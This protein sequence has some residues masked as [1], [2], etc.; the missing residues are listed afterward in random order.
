MK[1]WWIQACQAWD[2]WVTDDNFALEIAK[3][4]L[5]APMTLMCIVTTSTWMTDEYIIKR[6][7]TPGLETRYTSKY[8]YVQGEA[9]N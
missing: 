5:T 6:Y 3:A 9:T 1:T 2:E 7:G 4:A 8:K